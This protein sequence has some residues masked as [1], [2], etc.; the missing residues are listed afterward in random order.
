M[1]LVYNYLIK[2]QKQL[3][4]LLDR[5][6]K[7]QKNDQSRYE[8]EEGQGIAHSVQHPE[9][10]HQMFEPQLERMIKT[11]PQSLSNSYIVCYIEI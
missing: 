7:A 6:P 10:H 4:H 11:K 2:H 9:A 8:R 1:K 5:L 3:A